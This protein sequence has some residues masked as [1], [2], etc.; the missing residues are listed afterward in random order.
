MD[1]PYKK[2]EHK[3]CNFMIMKENYK[4]CDV[5]NVYVQLE[6]IVIIIKDYNIKIILTI[7]INTIEQ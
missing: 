2:N 3:D 7:M 1:D 5:N 6:S 4:I